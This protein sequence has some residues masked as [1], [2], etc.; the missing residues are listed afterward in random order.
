MRL[1]KAEY[2]QRWAGEPS[3][4]RLFPLSPSETIKKGHQVL[5]DSDEQGSSFTS[6]D[7]SMIWICSPYLN[8]GAFDWLCTAVSALL[9]GSPRDDLYLVTSEGN[10]PSNKSHQIHA[11][12]QKAF[13]RLGGKVW[14]SV[15][16]GFGKVKISAMTH[17]FEPLLHSKLYV[18][19]KGKADSEFISVPSG[20][21][22]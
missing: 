3:Q 15:Y 18:C 2:T 22:V 7:E 10:D 21:D 11:W 19:I 14:V 6:T 8:A 4:F 17:L 13:E 20:E 16:P 9:D 12:A 1:S 5:F